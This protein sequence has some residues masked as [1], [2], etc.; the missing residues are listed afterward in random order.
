MKKQ[1]YILIIA[2][3]LLS[4]VSVRIPPHIL[5]VAGFIT[6]LIP[7]ILILNLVL[8]IRDLKNGKLSFLGPLAILL[9]G[10]GFITDTFSWHASGV[11]GTLKVLSFNLRV[12]NIYDNPS[13]KNN[14]PQKMADWIRNEKSDI[15]CLQEFY[16]EPGSSPLNTTKM[17]NREKDYRIYSEPVFT[18]RV[19][20]Q[21]G[22]VIFSR[23]P[24]LNSGQI[25]FSGHTQNQ[26]IFADIRID[27]DTVRIYNL[28]LQSMH[29]DEKELMNYDND[30]ENE[31]RDLFGRLKF[32][33]IQR[34]MQIK[35]I[36]QHII[37]CPYRVIV[38]G[39]FN[40]LP[41]SYAY[42]Q[43]KD[44]LNN[45]FAKTGR[46]FGFTYNGRLPFLRIDNQFYSKGIKAESFQTEK[47]MK[48]SDH[49]P[50]VGT[51]TLIDQQAS[52]LK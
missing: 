41:Y 37:E 15:I 27:T 34:S 26:A 8:L 22:T 14:I 18:N 24:I 19:G 52:K 44:I 39:D 6:Y 23:Y 28:H 48:Y 13:M 31:V 45:S 5:W 2:L 12:F 20:A 47:K 40:D 51:Y 7:F 10:W 29:I 11:P 30:I 3:S 21:F 9:L 16:T 49:F 36:K 4:Y 46:G 50:I 25:R 43:L 42:H 1:V 17:I 38:C 32:G 35:T 33:F